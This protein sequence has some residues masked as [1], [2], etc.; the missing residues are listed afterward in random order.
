MTTSSHPV[1]ERFH[2]CDLARTC[3]VF[4]LFDCKENDAVKR[5]STDL[6]LRTFAEARYP[7]AEFAL[8]TMAMLH[9]NPGGLEDVVIMAV[10]LRTGPETADVVAYAFGAVHGP[11]CVPFTPAVWPDAKD[12][13][14]RG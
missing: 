11:M 2:L 4:G 3:E 5:C 8:T 1:P 13:L 10:C 9:E 12:C 14:P 7:G 6:E